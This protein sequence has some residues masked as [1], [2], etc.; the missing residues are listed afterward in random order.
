MKRAI[1]VLLISLLVINNLGTVVPYGY[2]LKDSNLIEF[3]DDFNREFIDIYDT[4]YRITFKID[5]STDLNH[6]LKLLQGVITENKLSYEVIKEDNL[7]D[8]KKNNFCNIYTSD[9][10]G[11]NNV[12]IDMKLLVEDNIDKLSCDIKIALKDEIIKLD[13]KKNF[14]LKVNDKYTMLE[15]KGIV[16]DYL[17]KNR[18]KVNLVDIYN[19]YSMSIKKNRDH[20]LGFKLSIIEYDKENYILF[21]E[22]DIYISY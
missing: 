16:E 19:G 15:I 6:T 5:K 4:F 7:R 8:I 21:G 3:K 12:I 1:I 13:T 10:N 11:Y 17:K 22:P 20:D 9:T 18:Y 14:R 2:N